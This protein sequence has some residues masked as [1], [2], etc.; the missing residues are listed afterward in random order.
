MGPVKTMGQDSLERVVRAVGI[1]T[2]PVWLDEIASTNDE[3]RRLADEGAPAW[4]VVAAGHQT[5]GRGR[6]GRSWTD[7]PGKALLF[8]VVL[9][10]AMLPE[11]APVLGLLAAVE[12]IAASA[13]PDLRARWPNDLVHGDRKVGGILTEGEVAGGRVGHVVVGVGVNLAMT[14]ADFPEDLRSKATS[15]AGD[16]GAADPEALLTGF[17]AGLRRGTHL[18]LREVVEKYREVCDTLGR[19][20]RATTTS[21]EV[22]EGIAVD[23]DG[24]GGLVMERAGRRVTVAFG[25]VE[26]LR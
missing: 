16:V 18:P 10:P 13:R 23:L 6:L 12:M 3:A 20:V 17:L 8:S 2:R 5:A 15:L 1:D 19:R 25:E 22:L 11:E 4:T 9:R 24:L 7:M 21:G 26:H 14:D